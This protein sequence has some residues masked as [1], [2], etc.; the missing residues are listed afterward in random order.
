MAKGNIQASR[1]HSGN[2]GYYLREDECEAYLHSVHPLMSKEDV[3]RSWK[4]IEHDEVFGNKSLGIRGRHDAQ[5]RTNYMMTMPN[6]LSHLHIIRR[7]EAIIEKTPIKDCTYTICVHGGRHGEV[8]ENKHVHLLVN[9][10]SLVTGKKVRELSQKPFLEKLKE[11]YRKEFALELS[12]GKEVAS[13]ERI[14]TSLWK[15]SPTLAR[16][17]CVELQKGNKQLQE[18]KGVG[19]SVEH[20]KIVGVLRRTIASHA[21]EKKEILQEI[22]VCRDQ[23]KHL[24]LEISELQRKKAITLDTELRWERGRVEKFQAMKKDCEESTWF[25][26]TMT[27]GHTKYVLA[28]LEK[29][30]NRYNNELAAKSVWFDDKI[31]ELSKLKWSLEIRIER[32]EEKERMNTEEENLIPRQIDKAVIA[33]FDHRLSFEEKKKLIY[34]GIVRVPIK[35]YIGKTGVPKDG[36]IMLSIDESK[37]TFNQKFFTQEEVTRMANM[38]NR[39]ENNYRHLR[40]ESQQRIAAYQ[41]EK[42]QAQEKDQTQDRNRGFGM[43]R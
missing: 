42:E 1:S 4:R 43:S 15:A 23:L 2:V 17:L 16:E 26:R 29:A 39:S 24:P 14:D 36:E 11:I 34:Q 20:A 19:V 32:A 41:K 21:A 7:V 8:A 33:V 22:K 28:E 37:K 6:D 3:V 31:R 10:R 35:D 9:E 27:P 13:R 30:E 5:V 18:K 40:E 12:Q 38:Q 25:I